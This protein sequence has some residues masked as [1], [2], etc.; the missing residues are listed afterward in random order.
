MNT[1]ILLVSLILT[2]HLLE[3][4][5]C[6]TEIIKRLQDH[7]VKD[8]DQ[9]FLPFITGNRFLTVWIARKHSCHECLGGSV[10]CAWAK[11]EKD[12]YMENVVQVTHLYRTQVISSD[13]KTEEKRALVRLDNGVYVEKNGITDVPEYFMYPLY[14]DK[15]EG[16]V[17]YHRCKIDRKHPWYTIIAVLDKEGEPKWSAAKS[18]IHS[19]KLRKH[20]LYGKYLD[21]RDCIHHVFG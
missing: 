7:I 13:V 14:F 20:W 16:V 5:S 18:K 15:R 19:L 21:Y 1:R 2:L 4:D 12:K 8:E 9:E 10:I 11:Y 6:D 17:A 3:I